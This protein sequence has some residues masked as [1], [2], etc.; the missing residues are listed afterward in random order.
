[1]DQHG[2]NTTQVANFRWPQGED[3]NI[4]LRYKEGDT[5][6]S[7]VV[8]PLS[9]GY[10]AR[11]DIVAPTTGNSLLTLSSNTGEITLSNGSNGGPNIEV[12]APRAATFYPGAVYTYVTTQG[13]GALVYD[14]FLRNTQTNKQVKILRGTITLEKSNTQWQ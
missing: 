13:A 6:S 14:L 12:Y 5:T 4:Q 10:E 8:V 9:E 1:M 2:S 7:A 11:M 3:L